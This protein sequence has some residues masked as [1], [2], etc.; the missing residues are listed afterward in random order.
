MYSCQLVPT[1]FHHQV[2][3]KRKIDTSLAPS[4]I[5]SGAQTHQQQQRSR[6]I[7]T[8]KTEHIPDLKTN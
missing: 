1:E 2:K 4:H 8:N 3:G 7:H 6:K 5:L